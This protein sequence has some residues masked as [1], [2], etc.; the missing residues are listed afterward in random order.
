MSLCEKSYFGINKVVFL[1]ITTWWNK[2]SFTE[3]TR[4]TDQVN[5]NTDCLTTSL[6]LQLN[7][8]LCRVFLLAPL[9]SSLAAVSMSP[10]A[11]LRV[12]TVFTL[13][14]NNNVISAAMTDWHVA[15]LTS[16][17]CDARECSRARF[18]GYTKGSHRNII[19]DFTAVTSLTIAFIVKVLIVT[20]YLPQFHCLWKCVKSFK[21]IDVTRE[22]IKFF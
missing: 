20:I 7:V 8:F 16:S 22:R 18:L 4:Y 11:L 10:S 19:H 6:A 3:V 1:L 5:L 21:H 17:G 12:F 13:A 15:H 2:I 9:G 14:L